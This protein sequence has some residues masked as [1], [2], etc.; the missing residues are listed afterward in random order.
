MF[1]DANLID[2]RHFFVGEGCVVNRAYRV[3]KLC[4]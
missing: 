2:E 4:H 3:L 1:S